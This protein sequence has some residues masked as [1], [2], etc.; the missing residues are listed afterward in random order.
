ME[1]LEAQEWWLKFDAVA[2][3]AHLEISE[4]EYLQAYFSRKHGLSPAGAVI[5]I[6]HTRILNQHFAEEEN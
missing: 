4:R 3:A 5:A 1:K 2:Q 6:R